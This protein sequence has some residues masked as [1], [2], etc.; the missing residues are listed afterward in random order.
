MSRHRRVRLL[1]S[2]AHSRAWPFVVAKA[3]QVCRRNRNQ[4]GS[5]LRATALA[6]SDHPTASGES[7]PSVTLPPTSLPAIVW[8]GDTPVLQSPD[9]GT[10]RSTRA[11]QVAHK[12][13]RRLISTSASQA[14]K[15]ALKERRTVRPRPEECTGVAR[16]RQSSRFVTIRHD[17]TCHVTICSLPATVCL[18]I[19]SLGGN[20][21]WRDS[22]NRHFR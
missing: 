6:R 10:R 5:D 4:P 7:A 22:R 1:S 21:E 17:S 15:T 19:A 20:A 16:S 2:P 3:T 11:T 14:P 18:R 9:P 13:K 8:C 12:R